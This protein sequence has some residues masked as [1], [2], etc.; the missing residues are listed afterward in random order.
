MGLWRG[1]HFNHSLGSPCA[2]LVPFVIHGCQRV[3]CRSARRCRVEEFRGRT[4]VITGGGGGI[5]RALAVAFAR[6]GMNVVI[7]EIDMDAAA[8]TVAAVEEHGVRAIAVQNDV[9]DRASMQALADATNDAFGG[10]HI[11]CNNAGVVTFKLAQ[12]MT[13]DDWDWVLGVDLYGVIYGIQAFL[14]GMVAAGEGGHIVNTASI[15]GLV[16]P[17]TPGI[18]SYSAAK[19]GVVGISEALALDL[20]P[21]NIGVSVLC[22][23]GVRSRIVEAGRNRPEE[24]G[25]PEDPIREMLPGE[26]VPQEMLEPEDL[27]QK[28]LNAIRGNHLYV[29]SHPETQPAVEAR[30]QR[31]LDAYDLIPS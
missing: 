23:G 6:E 9:S 5:G 2:S 21:H 7:G 14:P 26:S 11:L 12:D 10:C 15:A 4:A 19:Y 20:E 8:G 3:D 31:I 28:V 24:Y 22:P 17:A 30:F 13:E 27:A 18:S 25:G 16:A 1:H 29:V